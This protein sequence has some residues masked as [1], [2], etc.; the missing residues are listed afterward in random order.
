MDEEAPTLPREV[1]P[2]PEPTPEP[3]PEPTPEEASWVSEHAK[4]LEEEL[5]KLVTTLAECRPAEPLRFLAELLGTGTTTAERPPS[6]VEAEE[7]W[8]WSRT[9][10]R[11][12]ASCPTL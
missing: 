3:M 11:S 7:A 2:T 5:S 9:E 4:A 8:R 6:D 1:E 12:S 10:P